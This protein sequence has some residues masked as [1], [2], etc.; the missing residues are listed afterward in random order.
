VLDPDKLEDK[1]RRAL[2]HVRDSE[3]PGW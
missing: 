1:V 2:G 3:V